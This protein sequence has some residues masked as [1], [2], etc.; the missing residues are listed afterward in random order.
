MNR[1]DAEQAERGGEAA[2]DFT[3]DTDLNVI[4]FLIRMIHVNPWPPSE[5]SLAFLART[6]E[7]AH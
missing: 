6:L 1:R 2:T 5:L 7:T 3:N 4:K